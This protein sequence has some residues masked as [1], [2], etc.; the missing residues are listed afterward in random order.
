MVPVDPP[1]KLLYLILQLKVGIREYIPTSIASN[2][3]SQ[4]IL[5]T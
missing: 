1:S 4:V 3:F 5:F 2:G